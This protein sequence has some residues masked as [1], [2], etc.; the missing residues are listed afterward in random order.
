[1]LKELFCTNPAVRTAQGILTHL[2]VVCGTVAV[3]APLCLNFP[4]DRI[5]EP[6]VEMTED[7]AS[8][9]TVIQLFTY[10]WTMVL[11]FAILAVP[12]WQLYPLKMNFRKKVGVMI[13]FGLGFG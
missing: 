4:T 13:A 12:I 11:D 7:D 9:E 6:G 8:K 10:V 1:M 2:T 3:T 5:C